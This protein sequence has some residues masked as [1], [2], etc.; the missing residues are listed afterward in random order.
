MSGALNGIVVL[1]L[2]RFIAGPYASMLL[3][4]MGAEV[5]RIE[6]P[7]GAEDRC[8]G[9]TLPNGLHLSHGLVLG[10]NK[11]SVTLNLR[12]EKGL[13]ILRRMAQ[14]AD[15]MIH[16]YPVGTPESSALEYERL[17]VWNNHLIVAAISGFG[18]TGP[19]ARRPA[20]DAIVQGVSG[21]MSYNGSPGS[22]PLR[23]GIPA[24]DWGSGLHAAFG[25]MVAI[26]SRTNSGRGQLVDIS[27][28]DAAVSCVAAS[29]VATDYRTLGI[30]RQKLGNYPAHSFG[31]CFP[32]SD[33]WFYVSAV[34]NAM[35]R[36]FL[37]VLGREDMDSDPRFSDDISRQHHREL[38][39]EAITAW[40]R[41]RTNAE[42][43]SLFDVAQVPVGWVNDIPGLLVDPQVAARQMLVDVDL[44]GGLQMT[45]PGIAVK[46]SDTPGTIVRGSPEVGEHN[47][48]IY[49]DWL[50]L[51][52]HSLAELKAEGIL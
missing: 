20:F 16:S 52:R 42:V 28:L 44:P 18:Q 47:H 21:M 14:K 29:G 27:M 2:S 31:G 24:L 48:E 19:Y 5:I 8:V 11:K 12:S 36:R 9:E 13:D 38:I 1:D 25:I 4:D 35:W 3:A 22:P 32:S 33:G 40:S 49:G 34:G 45:A 50:G 39:G 15:V 10:R 7:G 26:H 43:V 51:D 17:C 37:R 46:L 23:T 41:S 6:K 30:V